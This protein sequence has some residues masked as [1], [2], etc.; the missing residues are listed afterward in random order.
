MTIN[1]HLKPDGTAQKLV[2]ALR[3]GRKAEHKDVVRSADLDVLLPEAHPAR[4]VW[5]YVSAQ[6]LGRLDAAGGSSP[7]QGGVPP[8]RRVMLALWL[9]AA[10]QGVGSARTLAGLCESHAAYR[11]LRGG[12]RVAEPELK[13]CRLGPGSAVDEWLADCVAGISAADLRLPR[14]DAAEGPG[15]E[16]LLL[17]IQA[18]ARQRIQQLKTQIDDAGGE[19]ARRLTARKERGRRTREARVAA[20][21]AQ[22]GS[23]D[24]I[25]R[26]R[27]QEA[28]ARQRR[29]DEE[30]RNRQRQ[31]EEAAQAKRAAEA[32]ALQAMAPP[33]AAPRPVRYRPAGLAVADS[34][35]PWSIDL[36]ETARFRRI[37]GGAFGLFVVLSI[38]LSLIKPPPVERAEAEKVPTRLAKLILEQKEAPKKPE[39]VAVP[40]PL[41]KEPEKEAEPAP[42][43]PKEVKE[44]ERKAEAPKREVAIAPKPQHSDEEVRNAREKASK[45]G[46]LV[47]RDQLAALRELGG[48]GRAGA[49]GSE[50]GERDLITRRGSGGSGPVVERD[51][52]AQAATSGSGGVSAKALPH[53]GGG[54]LDVRETTRVAVAAGKPSIAEAK[55][56]ARAGRRTHEEIKLAFDANKAAIYGIYRRALRDNPLLEGRVVVKLTIDGSGEV[57]ACSIVSSALKD[58][59]LEAKLVARIQLINFGARAKVEAWTGTYHIDFVPAS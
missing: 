47:M 17:R 27:E 28:L 30:A 34:R 52:I 7:V 42:E 45:S 5:G 40:E 3:L 33:G 4:I 13:Q 31:E 57:T 20:A 48:Q 19:L 11:W 26:Q 10:L 55:E 56:E 9:Y 23:L 58:P 35:L 1:D 41:K 21:V 25:R 15:Q 46:L 14:P 43:A 50:R 37:V 6:D 8:E 49:E 53:S 59:E 36:A 44:P 2:E 16:A 32:A 38:L 51:L 22:L 54:S 12:L 39:P 24:A 18:E 29:L